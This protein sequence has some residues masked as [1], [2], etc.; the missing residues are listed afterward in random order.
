MVKKNYFVLRSSIMLLSSIVF[1]NVVKCQPEIQDRDFLSLKLKTSKYELSQE[2][3]SEWKARQKESYLIKIQALPDSVKAYFINKADKVL[4]FDWPSLPASSYLE[5]KK[6]GNRTRYEKILNLRRDALNMLAI[7]ELIVRNKKYMP[8][9]V[10]GVWATLEESTWEIPA[11]VAMQKAG[12]DLPDPSENI[13]GLVGAETAVMVASIQHMFYDQLNEYSP[14]INKRIAIE[15]N[16]RI[17]DPYLQRDDYWWMGF[18]SKAVNNWNAWI[19]TNVLHTALLSERNPERLTLLISKV[20]K[21]TDYFINQYPED[22]GCDEGPSYWSLAGGKL[23]R[24][25]QLASSVSNGKLSWSSNGLLHSIGSYIYKMHIA[26]EYFVNFADATSRTIPNPESVYRFGEMF[27]DDSLKQF[28]AYLFSLK[29]NAMP[30]NSVVDFLETA[31][32]YNQ[33]TSIIPKA[34]LLPAS[35]LPDLQILTVRS[36]A[37]KPSLFLA[38]QGGNNGESHNHNDVGNFLIYANGKPVI[39]DAGVGTY[40]AQTF[41]STRYEL[42]NMQSQ[43]HN[44]PV[45]NGVMQMDGKAFSASDVSFEKKRDEVMISMD[46]SGAYPSSSFVKK[47]ERRFLFSQRKNS[48]T[49]TEKYL[50]EKRVGQTSVNFLSSCEFRPGKTGEIIFYDADGK[51]VLLLQYTPEKMVFRREEKIPDDEKI[52]NEWGKKIYRLSFL[53][54]DSAIKGKNIFEFK[55]PE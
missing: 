20:F 19:N 13:I 42:W 5:Y 45:I 34:V 46:I 32:V 11:I 25:L 7:G 28:G 36:K 55:V 47:W 1:G 51:Q 39:I 29:K 6:T 40:T 18:T 33:L 16:K 17:L 48:V 30:D 37:A 8:Q 31:D 14:V 4:L 50:L 12:K 26:G 54:S 49:L 35:F 24:L 27:N 43:W 41:S 10:N 3:I 21:S 52:E 22:G 53:L 23:I 9:I 38:V 15:L 2:A 44:C